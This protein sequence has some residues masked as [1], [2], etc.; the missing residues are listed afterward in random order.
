[1]C[2][3]GLGMVF[4]VFSVKQGYNFTIWGLWQGVFRSEAFLKKSEKAADER[5]T[6]VAPTI[7]SKKK[8]LVLK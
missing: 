2:A 4:R 8:K 1:M 7:F 6:F 3:G 5:S